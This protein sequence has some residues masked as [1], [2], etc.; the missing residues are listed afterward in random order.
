MTLLID[1]E[2]VTVF[3]G[4]TDRKGNVNKEPSGTVGVVFGWGGASSS[5]GFPGDRDES[6][7]VSAQVYVPVGADVRSRDR[8]ERANGERY[9]V[10]GHA[11][12]G[13]PTGLNVFGS[14][15][16]VFEVESMNG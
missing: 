13:Q 1:V 10:I 4:G 16:A 14:E 15:W 7:S 12:W 11:M 2:T 5:A 3:R 9:A 8:L 6:S